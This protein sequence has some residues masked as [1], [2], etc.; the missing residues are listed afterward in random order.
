VI[1]A[2][3]VTLFIRTGGGGFWVGPAVSLIA[4]TTIITFAAWTRRYRSH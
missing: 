3:F 1:S 2:L 4:F